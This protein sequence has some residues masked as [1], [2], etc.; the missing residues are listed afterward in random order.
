[1]GFTDRIAGMNT[2]TAQL[3]IIE[4]QIQQAQERVKYL[5]RERDNLMAGIDSTLQEIAALLHKSDCKSSHEDRCAWDYEEH[6]VRTGNILAND[7][8]TSSMRAHNQWARTAL[9][10]IA[11]AGV[12]ADEYLTALKVV[13]AK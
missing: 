7:I 4:Q 13:M 9:D 6:W 5:Q 12:S 3:V 2:S 8:W 11:K 10:R 1:M